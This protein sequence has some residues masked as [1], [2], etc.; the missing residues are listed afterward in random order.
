MNNS[1]RESQICFFLA[2]IGLLL[3]F[4]LLKTRSMSDEG[5]III[6]V[7]ST[8]SST[9]LFIL[10]FLVLLR[11]RPKILR[12]LGRLIALLLGIGCLRV[13]GLSVIPP[14]G[15]GPVSQSMIVLSVFVFLAPGVLVSAFGLY[16]DV[17]LSK[18]FGLSRWR[19]YRYSVR[20]CCLTL[21]LSPIVALATEYGL[22]GN[23]SDFSDI[24][25]YALQIVVSAFGIFLESEKLLRDR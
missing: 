5:L 2:G 21:G 10:G 8:V 13:V 19:I 9:V 18:E 25:K 20:L 17:W 6:L 7:C 23:S 16:L 15:S 11:G 24:A 12:F 3:T 22:H 4:F 1:I 14:S